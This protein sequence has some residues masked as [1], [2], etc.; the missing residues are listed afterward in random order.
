MKINKRKAILC[1]RLNI[2]MTTFFK[3][4]YKFSIIL[5]KNPKDYFSRFGVVDT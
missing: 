2:K 1:T 5:I 3:L 4:I